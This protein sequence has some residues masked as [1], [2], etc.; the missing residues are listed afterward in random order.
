MNDSIKSVLELLQRV[1]ADYCHRERIPLPT[2]IVQ[3]EILIELNVRL[4]Q[5]KLETMISCLLLFVQLKHG[6]LSNPLQ[7][8]NNI[9]ELTTYTLIF[10][11]EKV[12]YSLHDFCSFFPPRT[13]PSLVTLVC[14]LSS[15]KV[16]A[17]SKVSSVNS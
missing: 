6:E 10:H 11:R 12:L 2:N 3:E 13:D 5:Y 7:I 17:M 4:L 15:L 14:T 9:R 16:L 1:V 8:L